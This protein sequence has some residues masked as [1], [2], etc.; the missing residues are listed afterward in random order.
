MPTRPR[1][2]TKLPVK[3][4]SVR[5]VFC[6]NGNVNINLTAPSGNQYQI[7]CRQ[8]FTIQAE[9][10]DFFFVNWDWKFR[11]RLFR[12]G[13][14]PAD[15]HAYNDANDHKRKMYANPGGETSGAKVS[16]EKPT[17]GLTPVATTEPKK[18]EPTPE[19]AA[20]DVEDE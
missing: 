1:V 17:P 15:P 7:R 3:A 13:E 8:P 18:A 9:D 12:E 10:E 16:D 19:P 14:V 6:P 4:K 2:A 20:K 5:A 11:Q